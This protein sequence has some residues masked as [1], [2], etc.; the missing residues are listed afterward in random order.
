MTLT[1][2]SIDRVEHFDPDPNNPAVTS[3]FERL[4]DG[5]ISFWC[6]HCSF[7]RKYGTLT[8]AITSASEHYIQLHRQRLRLM[9]VRK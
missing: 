7:T 5:G 6:R 4:D 8:G 2:N 3:R 1:R 9:E